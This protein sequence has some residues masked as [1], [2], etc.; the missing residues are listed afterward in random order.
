MVQDAIPAGNFWLYQMVSTIQKENIVAVSCRQIPKSDADLFACSGI[1]NH[2]R[3]LNLN[4]DHVFSLDA[5][6]STYSF[7]DRRRIAGLD[8]VCSL[9]R[10][11][12]FD[13]YRFRA[14][15]YG[16]DLD[17][18]VRIVRDGHRI[19]FL[20]SAGVIHSHN[21]DAAYFL[22]RGFVDNKNVFRILEYPPQAD[23]AIRNVRDLF[24]AAIT[25]YAALNASVRSV[26]GGPGP[27]SAQ[28]IGSIQ[29]SLRTN[30]DN[31]SVISDHRNGCGSLDVFFEKMEQL[32]GP[33][34]YRKSEILTTM[35]VTILDDLAKYLASIRYQDTKYDEFSDAVY[36][37]CATV[38]GAFM[39]H[40]YLQAAR[41][42][43]LSDDI[44]LLDKLLR[45][46][47]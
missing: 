14:Q 24:C 29:S 9:I 27:A 8:N 30:L 41:S 28:S 1:W 40:Y 16:E 44:L 37:Y 36:K 35:F 19:A 11:D 26:Q 3:I 47:I 7:L 23:F 4:G 22:K 39:A 38:A 18:G 33:P 42:D 15:D 13:R 6:L 12:I 31:P 17:L 46:G 2:Y 43:A 25:L 32:Y 21:R 34:G 5:D 20:S 10:K 45:E